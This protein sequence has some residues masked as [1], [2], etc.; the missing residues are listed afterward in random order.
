MV[1][2]FHPSNQTSECSADNIP[3]L[4]VSD[5]EK[6]MSSHCLRGSERGIIQSTI[7]AASV[8]EQMWGVWGENQLILPEF[9]TNTCQIS[10]PK[11]FDKSGDA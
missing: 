5:R 2:Q 10:D 11:T 6:E 3:N 4:S 1:N 8:V 7:D 9:S